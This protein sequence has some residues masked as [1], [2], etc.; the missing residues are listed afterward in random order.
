MTLTKACKACH[1]HFTLSEQEVKF[2]LNKF[3]N[4]TKLCQ[5]CR[6]RRRVEAYTC[7]CTTC[8]NTFVIDGLE[9]FL[10]K[11]KMPT[12]CDTCIEA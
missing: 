8:N 2:S 3:G 10:L 5:P 12:Q 7:H 6:T 9:L 11:N 4:T 1:N